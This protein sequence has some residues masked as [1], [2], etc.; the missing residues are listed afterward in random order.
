M[1]FTAC[2]PNDVEMR[3]LNQ[4]EID[5]HLRMSPRGA[6]GR[7]GVAIGILGYY[8]ILII[9]NRRISSTTTNA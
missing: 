9:N 8:L 2:G 4:S 3:F 7:A 1:I 5:E 6:P